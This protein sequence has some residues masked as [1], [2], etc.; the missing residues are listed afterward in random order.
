MTQIQDDKMADVTPPTDEPAESPDEI[1][2]P[3]VHRSHRAVVVRVGVAALLVGAGAVGVRLLSTPHLD[4]EPIDTPNEIAAPISAPDGQTVAPATSEPTSSTLDPAGPS[5]DGSFNAWLAGAAQTRPAEYIDPDYSWAAY[6]INSPEALALRFDPDADYAI[7]TADGAEG[8]VDA[9]YT[10]TA[11]G[12]ELIDELGQPTDIQLIGDTLYTVEYNDTGGPDGIDRSSLRAFDIATRT[13]SDVQTPDG[14]FPP[15]PPAATST[16]AYHYSSLSAIGDTLVV[17]FESIPQITE[18]ELGEQDSIWVEGDGSVRI[19]TVDEECIA[20]V[21]TA[22]DQAPQAEHDAPEAECERE[23]APAE[24]GLTDADVALIDTVESTVWT[25]KDGD[26][27]QVTI[28]DDGSDFIELADGGVIEAIYQPTSPDWDASI[29]LYAIDDDTVRPLF[30]GKSFMNFSDRGWLRASQPR[31]LALLGADSYVLSQEVASNDWSATDLDGLGDAAG[32]ANY[33]IYAGR[34]IE[35]ASGGVVGIGSVTT[36]LPTEPTELTSGDYTIRFEPGLAGDITV[37]NN[38]SGD[39]VE[40]WFISTESGQVELMQYGDNA[41]QPKMSLATFDTDWT[42]VPALN[43]H[44]TQIVYASPDG[45]RYGVVDADALAALI[46]G[47]PTS[48][49]WLDDV[50]EVDGRIV[51]TGFVDV[52]G[53]ASTYVFVGTPN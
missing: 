24:V 41:D 7:G 11:D 3:A 20:A 16:T 9:L 37:T 6:P 8:L 50:Q 51:V 52:M 33:C 26:W 12:W 23:L 1:M 21:A 53:T 25:L 49:L 29:R 22:A 17:K 46:D 28:P 40:D 30:D 32:W 38:T 44:D 39:L 34:P 19:V 14:A 18:A 2:I 42:D 35:T 45:I 4:S 43:T 27:R 31:S 13:W 47:A 48:R 5:E 36:G 15:I 10:K